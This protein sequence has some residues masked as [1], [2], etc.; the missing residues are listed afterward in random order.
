[1]AHPLDTSATIYIPEITDA[2][3]TAIETDANLLTWAK[4][5]SGDS[6]YT[7]SSTGDRRNVY[8]LPT[9]DSEETIITKNQLTNRVTIFVCLPG[10]V[11]LPESRCI[12][13]D[14]DYTIL[15]YV[16]G[17]HGQLTAVQW[18]AEYLIR[19]L[20]PDNLSIQ[21]GSLAYSRD[22]ATDTAGA[23]FQDPNNLQTHNVRLDYRVVRKMGT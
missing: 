3:V 22:V 5:F 2:L 9:Y 7:F 18:L 1:M 14:L 11:R 16:T 23:F 12:K 17:Q 13:H 10:F 6:N 21:A 4:D 15:G 8:I 20:Q 19:A